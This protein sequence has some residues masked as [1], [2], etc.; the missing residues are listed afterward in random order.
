M[1]AK[2]NLIHGKSGFCV[3]IK[4]KIWQIFG[5][6]KVREEGYH[7]FVISPLGA[8]TSDILE[9]RINVMGNMWGY[10]RTRRYQSFGHYIDFHAKSSDFARFFLFQTCKTLHK[11]L[12]RRTRNL[13]PINDSTKMSFMCS[14]GVQKG[15]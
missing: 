9:T 8:V 10:W 6:Q 11:T 7:S 13:D 2:R 15:P 14:T 3:E 1:L 4:C 5:T 12:H